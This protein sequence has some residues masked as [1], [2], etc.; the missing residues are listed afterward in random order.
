MGYG[1]EAHG[2]NPSA[3]HFFLFLFIFCFNRIPNL[4]P[5]Y[6][7]ISIDIYQWVWLVPVTGTFEY[8]MLWKLSDDKPPTIIL[9]YTVAAY[10]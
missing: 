10:L 6:F 3:R 5:T 1:F 7:H 8:L 4:N 9:G 2:F